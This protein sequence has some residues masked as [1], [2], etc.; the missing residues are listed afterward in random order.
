MDEPPAPSPLIRRLP[1]WLPIALIILF[2]TGLRLWIVSHAE[3]AARDSIGFIS[4]ALKLETGPWLQVVKTAEQPPG[5]ALA[6]LVVSWPMRWWAGGLTC[7]AMALS[8]QLASLIAGVLLVIPMY[9]L[10]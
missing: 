2:G 9:R 7:E 3:V 4:Y 5:Y 1:H 10:G 8:T 6:V